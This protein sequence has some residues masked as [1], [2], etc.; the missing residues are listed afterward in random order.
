MKR[1]G[2]P[3]RRTPLRPKPQPPRPRTPV[4]KRRDEPRRRD[5]ELETGSDNDWSSETRR[6]VRLR[7]KGV[8]EMAGCNH[9]A[10]EMHHRKLR[11]H[12]D[13]RAANC[14]HLCSAHHA[15][16]HAHPLESYERGWLVRSTLDPA[17]VP[18]VA[19]DLPLD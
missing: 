8:C 12:G 14:L 6:E 3:K 13:H 10:T 19:V 7:S 9:P 15:W 4:R 2:P 1:S 5:R 17:K 18:V 11:A 16:I